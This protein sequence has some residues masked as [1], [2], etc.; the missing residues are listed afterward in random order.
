MQKNCFTPL[1]MSFILQTYR[2]GLSEEDKSKSTKDSL[3]ATA[4]L[5]VIG[6]L[7]NTPAETI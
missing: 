4:V 5:K 1:R 2:P 7:I 6:A 3:K